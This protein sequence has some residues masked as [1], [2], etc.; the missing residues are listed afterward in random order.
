MVVI[1]LKGYH[2]IAK[3]Q[4]Y[5]DDDEIAEEETPLL[6]VASP[7]HYKCE[8]TIGDKSFNRFFII[9]PD[10]GIIFMMSVSS[11]FG[12]LFRFQSCW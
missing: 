2:S 10:R 5:I 1:P 3:Y 4:W 11:M 9:K 6:Y 7:A 12:V 8:V